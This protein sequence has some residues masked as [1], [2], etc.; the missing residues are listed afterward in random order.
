M[1][2][3]EFDTTSSDLPIRVLLIDDD[4]EDHLITRDLL[5][6]IPDKRFT[7][8]WV[9]NYD[10][11][12][13][14]LGQREHD[15][16]LLDY[17]LGSHS[18]L[19]LL[20]EARMPPG[21][22]PFIVLTGQGDVEVDQSAQ[23][24]GAADYLVKSGLSAETLDRSIRYALQ[25]AGMLDALAR[26]RA[27]L[28]RRVEERT[29]ELALTNDRLQDVNARLEHTVDS[30]TASE[31]RFRSLVQTIPDVVYKIDVDGCFTFLNDAIQRYGYHQVDLL[32]KH[33]SEVMYADDVQQ[34]SRREVAAKWHRG[35]AEPEPKVFDERRRAERMTT[36][37]QLRL[38]KKCGEP[39]DMMEIASLSDQMAY[40]EVNSIGMYDKFDKSKLKYVGTVGVMRSIEE[41]VKAEKEILKA[42]EAAEAANRA[43]S[44]F[45]ANMSHEIRTPMNAII[46]MTHLALQT[47]QHD[48]RN[49]YL[50]K[51]QHAAEG[52]LGIIN[53]ILDFSKIEAGHLTLERISFR[54]EDV[55]EQFANLV[56]MR[57]EEKGIE[58]MFDVDLDVPSG[59]L[60][61]PLRLGQILINLGNNAV[62]FTEPGGEI[63]VGVRADERS[64]N[65]LSLRFSV[66]DTG[67]GMTAE[68]QARLF[69][70]FTQADTSTA[71][72]YGGTGLGLAISKRLTDAMGGDIWVESEAGTGS[73]FHFT[74]PFGIQKEQQLRPVPG[75][76]GALRVLV[77]DDNATSRHILCAMLSRFGF[78]VSEAHSGSEA[79]ALI[80]SADAGSPYELVLMDWKMPQMN[81]IEAIRSIQTNPDVSH[82][83]TV[84]MVTAY[85]REELR[86]LV[87]NVELAGIL[88]KPVSPSALLD[89]ILLAM[90]REPLSESRSIQHQDDYRSAVNKLR[91]AR[92]LL[93]EDNPINQEL[94]LELLMQNGIRVEAANNG[95]EAISRLADEVF[96]GVLMD[97]QM[98][99]MDGYEATQKIREMPRFADLPIIAMTANALTGDRE[100]VLSV[101]MNDHIAKPINLGDLFNTLA[102][103][104][105]PG[106]PDQDDPVPA[107]AQQADEPAHGFPRL[108]GID[109]DAGL[110]TT[111]NNVALYRKLLLRFRDSQSEF[112]KLFREAQN[113]EEAGAAAREAHSLKGVAANL[114]IRRLQQV[115]EA[116]ELACKGEEGQVE[117]LLAVVACELERVLESLEQLDEGS[118]D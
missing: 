83:P 7:L 88:T 40:V 66:S 68:Q 57:A 51:V 9:D 14:R 99:V 77:V 42:K 4:E 101:G 74:V 13:Q 82:A 50:L 5:E 32:G 49:N 27:N 58:L 102:K 59:L 1:N 65:D 92:L 113:S 70:S 28:A 81:G 80:E 95:Q 71:R 100:R 87:E 33:F 52:L 24:A 47:Q 61:D 94:A 116:L 16:C 23:E 25:H 17:R 84:I 48:R 103:W 38:K 118:S 44:E 8:E 46:G 90:G 72:T 112:E 39:A 117:D 105:R 43:K 98:P 34:V 21:S 10:D 37:M 114:G 86:Q 89:A 35:Q 63:V 15:I 108:S 79:V 115:A 73:T 91:G 29:R 107:P 96:D 69:Q 60:G 110:K 26:E 111:R 20:A 64:G 11:G 54:I 22:P 85:G 109:I 6:E 53:D 93:V 56:G 45:L 55:M 31:E 106:H 78:E 104:I 12:L 41:R 97:C 67:V 36:G 30:L 62:K 19:D 76:L 75:D 2:R 18:G 3:F